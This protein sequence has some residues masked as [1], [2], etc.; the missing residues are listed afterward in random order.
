MF[1]RRE[2]RIEQ[3]VLWGKEMGA[4]A[5]LSCLPVPELEIAAVVADSPIASIVG[6]L[7]RVGLAPHFP[8]WIGKILIKRIQ[9][10][11]LKKVGFDIFEAR[12]I[13]AV[14]DS[15][16]PVGF[17]CSRRDRVVSPLNAEELFLA[18]PSPTKKI[19]RA[20]GRRTMS[21]LMSATEY[22]CEAIGISVRFAR[23]EGED[24]GFD[25]EG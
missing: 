11:V 13:D 24:D 5:A 7:E 16:K 18:S 1:L 2:F 23:T 12:P 22:L 19:W 10:R 6:Y 15:Q 21:L 17:I 3:I 4:S 14:R 25:G 20:R 8:K 9:A